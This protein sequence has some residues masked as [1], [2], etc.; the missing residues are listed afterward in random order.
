MFRTILSDAAIHHFTKQDHI[1]K[2]VEKKRIFLI[3]LSA[4]SSKDL[5][6]VEVFHVPRVKRTVNRVFST[7]RFS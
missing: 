5:N 4:L 3:V 2:T 7:T 1:E 6:V